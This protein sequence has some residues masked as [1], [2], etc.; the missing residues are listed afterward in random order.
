MGVTTI[1]LGQDGF[2]APRKNLAEWMDEVDKKNPGTNIL[3]F[4]G[5]GT[6]RELSGIRFKTNP[7]EAEIDQMNELLKKALDAGCW[8]MTTG[9]EYTPGIYAGEVELEKLAQTVGQANGIIMSHIRNEDDD[10]VE[11]SI[12]ELLLQGRYCRVQVSHMKSVYGRGTERA[13]E[14]LALL[15]SARQAGIEVT[16]DVYPYSASYTGIGIVFPKWAK[17]PNNFEKVKKTRRAEL[18]DYL[19]K[20]VNKR[21]GPE[22]TLF[23]SGIFAGKTLGQAAEAVQKSFVDFLIDD[24]GPQGASAAYFVMNDTLQERLVQDSFVMIC[25]DG[26][27]TGR[28]PRGYGTFSKVIEEYAIQKQLFSLEEAIHKMT[29]LP[30]QTIGLDDRGLI[31][32]GKKADIAIFTPENIKEKATYE[33]PFQLAEGMKILFVNGNI[34]LRNGKP[35]QAGFGRILRNK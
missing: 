8:G 9:L 6:L 27:P 11:K 34:A 10:Q 33:D 31:Q 14:L 22:A 24:I 19:F 7:T 4:V 1:S 17:P 16:A 2:S 32:A 12:N 29:G 15:D 30:A 3:P 28:H 21:N 26:S 23:G 20:R 35:E 25:S 13:M 18:E 5:H